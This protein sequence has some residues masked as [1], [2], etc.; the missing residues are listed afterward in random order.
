MAPRQRLKPDERRN[1][2][3]DIGAHFFATRPYEEVL[4]EQVGAAAGVS[5]ALVYRYFPTKRDL[6]AAI[7]QR[8]A[9]QLLA[10]T[11]VDRTGSMADWVAAGLDAHIDYFVAHSHTV[12]A[13]NRGELSGDPRIQGIISEE[14]GTLRQRMLEVTGLDG[15]QRE[16]ASIALLAWLAFV[17]TICVEWLQSP[18]ISRAEL[19]DVCLHALL[20]AVGSLVDSDDLPRRAGSRQERRPS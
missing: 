4:M 10:A 3:L 19:R 12:L 14:L 13:A 7:Y 17:R 18:T 5:R 16:I 11:E 8:A 9:D 20:G 15:H 2:L 6:F 1:Q